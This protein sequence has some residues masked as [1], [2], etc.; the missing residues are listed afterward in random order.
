MPAAE[1][2]K[3]RASRPF[4][5]NSTGTLSSR[6]LAHFF[7]AVDITGLRKRGYT[8][9]IDRSDKMRGSSYRIGQD[10]KS[11]AKENATKEG[12]PSAPVRRSRKAAA[13]VDVAARR[14][15]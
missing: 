8:I 11:E 12:A 10:D 2:R 7:P 5:L 3:T 9:S 6:H 13:S 1:E 15:A 14:A 4:S